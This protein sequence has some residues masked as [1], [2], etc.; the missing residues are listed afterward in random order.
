MSNHDWESEM[1][2]EFDDR[3]RD[4]DAAPL[5]L[6]QVRGRAGSIRRTRRVAVAGAVLAGAAVVLPVGVV[7]SQGLGDDDSAPGPATSSA[8]SSQVPAGVDGAIGVDYLDGRTWVRPDGATIEL[9]ATYRGGTVLGETLLGVRND[10]ETGRH[11]LDVVSTDGEVGESVE[12]TSGLAVNEERTTVAY[13]EPD[14]DLMTLW[15]PA[16]GDQ[17]RV[18]IA[19]GVATG[20]VA[21][22]P[23][24][25][26]GGPS[27]YEAP[28]GEGCLVFYNVGDGVTPPRAASSHG[29]D[30]EVVFAGAPPVAVTDVTASGLLSVQQTSQVDGS[31]GG[32][33]EVSSASYLWDTCERY[34][35]DLN[36]SGSV[37]ATTHAYLDGDG[38]AFV[39]LVDTATEREVARLDPAE[40]TVRA[41]TWV[42]DRTLLAT[43]FDGRES[44]IWRL[45]S[46]GSAVPV[47]GASTQGDDTSPG[48]VLLTGY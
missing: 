20:D 9:A 1:S 7:A 6:D 43:V 37:V 12:L 24:A 15:D 28:Q 16:A 19:K 44:R 48:H 17:G 46:D 14:G 13:V 42:D 8:S 10:D 34:L 30:D 22:D 2:R 36:P 11:Y 26:T 29:I 4:L 27:C 5:S 23:V 41:Q 32:I 33:Y 47:T 45:S 38:F 35:L 18:V 3:V 25:V 40:G 39:A 21:V 31:C